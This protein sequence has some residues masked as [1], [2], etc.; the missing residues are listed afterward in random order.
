MTKVWQKD[1]SFP[2]FPLLPPSLPPSLPPYL[3]PLILGRHH[4]PLD[5][6]GPLG[7]KARNG[8]GDEHDAQPTQDGHA[9]LT[10]EEVKSN[11]ALVG[12]GPL[13]EG[14]REGGRGGGGRVRRMLQHALDSHAQLTV[15]GDGVLV[16][17]GPLGR[18]GGREGGR[19]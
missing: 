16:G 19:K 10:V 9:Q 18:E 2:F 7:H 13:R 5:R 14:G 12:G 3:D 6:P 1:Y 17:G 8:D 4:L 15:E 11:R